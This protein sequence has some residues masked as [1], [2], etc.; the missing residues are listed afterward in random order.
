MLSGKSSKAELTE[1]IGKS[2][3]LNEISIQ[4]FEEFSR[5]QSINY[6]KNSTRLA[7]FPSLIDNSPYT[8]LE[9][10]MNKV[11]FIATPVGGISELIHPDDR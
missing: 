5:E 8:I 1:F 4:F 6:L 10:I 7:V 11:N 2:T 9:C 3:I